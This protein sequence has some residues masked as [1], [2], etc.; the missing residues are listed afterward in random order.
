MLMVLYSTGMRNA[1]LRHLQVADIDSRAD[2]DSHSARE[3]R[4]RSVYP[5]QR[6]AAERRCACTAGGCGRRRGCFPGTV[7]NW[8]AD[9]PITPKVVWDACRSRRTPRRLTNGS[10][11]TCCAIRMPRICSKRGG[12]P[13]DSAAA[14]P[15]RAPAHRALSPSLPAA[16]AGRRQSARGDGD[17]RAGDRR[18]SRG[19]CTSGDAATLRGGRHRA[20]TW[21]SRPGD[22]PGLGDRAAST[23]P[24][25]HRAVP[26]RGTRWASRSLRPVRAAGPLVQQLSR[27]TLPEVSDRGAERVGRG[28]RAGAACPSATSTSSS[29]CRSRSPVSRSS[30]SAWCTTCCFRRPPTPCARSRAIRS[31][32]VVAIGGLMVLHTW[33]QRL[34]HHPHVHCV[35][36]MGGLAPD[37]TRWIH[38]RPR[39]FLPIP[40]LRQ[41]VSG[42]ARRR[43]PRGLSTRSPPSPGQSGTAEHGRRLPRLPPIALSSDV[44]RVR[45]AALR[46]SGPRAALPRALHAPRGHLQSPAG[47][48]SPTTPCRFGG[49]TIGTGARSARSRSTPTNFRERFL[50]HVLPKRFVRI[51]Y[52]GFFAPRCRTRELAQ[53]SAGPR[54]RPDHRRTSRA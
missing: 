25:G 47:G 49:R 41:A 31:A 38:A 13:H 3:G 39:F 6:R 4:T 18:R 21:R 46:Q 14:R 48:R 8:R 28:S 5:A 2:A 33:G 9:K 50:L 19:G 29:R 51:R 36:P 23:R 43:C 24:P 44:G 1:E 37:G 45:Q 32:W 42:Q 7:H 12:P 15:R 10:R 34:Q 27:S 11:P 54:R 20:P 17:S 22:A 26:N 52:C 16:S 53:W 35:V 30:T 40:V